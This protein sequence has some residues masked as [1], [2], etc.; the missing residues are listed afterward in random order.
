MLIFKHF[1]API[2]EYKH[3]QGLSKLDILFPEIHEF[4]MHLHDLCVTDV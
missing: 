1:Q 3:I 4:K 2:V